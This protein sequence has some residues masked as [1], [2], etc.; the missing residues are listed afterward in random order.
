MYLKTGRL[1]WET[2]LEVCIT[3]VITAK[4]AGC[5]L[6]VGTIEHAFRWKYP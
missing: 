2:H 6:L 5:I 1:I 4:N 3:T